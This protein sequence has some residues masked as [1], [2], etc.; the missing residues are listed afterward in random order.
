MQ[1]ECHPKYMSSLY[2][3]NKTDKLNSFL[4]SDNKEYTHQYFPC[5]FLQ[6][7]DLSS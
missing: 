3:I 1:Y 6:Q 2:K 7:N 5:L 4:V